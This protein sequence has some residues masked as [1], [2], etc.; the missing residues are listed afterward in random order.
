MRF[1]LALGFLLTAFVLQF[2][3]ITFDVPLDFVL[4]ALFAFA[5]VLDWPEL[6]F[7]VALAVFAIGW[8]PLWSPVVFIYALFPLLFYGFR[9]IFGLN[10]WLSL[11]I[12]ALIGIGALS[13]IAGP[14]VACLSWGALLGDIAA[15]F[16]FA[17][18]VFFALVHFS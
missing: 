2:W 4:A 17:L 6:L 10:A 11:L 16:G 8:R 5:M 12:A 1:T 15:S 18:F 7:F 14:A 3:A 13:L 9:R